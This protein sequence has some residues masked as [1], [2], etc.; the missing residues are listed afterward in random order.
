MRFIFFLN[1][2]TRTP[3]AR[4]LKLIHNLDENFR[5]AAHASALVTLFLHRGSS[6]DSKKNNLYPL[7]PDIINA[8]E[9]QTAGISKL[10]PLLGYTEEKRSHT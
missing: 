9:C 1:S 4:F 2:I 10:D 7:L 5:T 8:W 6:L 3:F